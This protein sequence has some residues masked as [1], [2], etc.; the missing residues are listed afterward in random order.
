MKNHAQKFTHFSCCFGLLLVYSAF[1][2]NRLKIESSGSTQITQPAPKEVFAL[3][4]DSLSVL[5]RFIPSGWMGD[6][7]DPERRWVDFDEASKT[8]PHSGSTCVKC[9]YRPGG[10][11]GF[12]A[13]AW[14]NLPDNWCYSPGRDYSAKGFTQIT[15]WARGEAGGELIRFSAGGE[16]CKNGG[17]Y[18]NSFQ[19][20][21]LSVT[22]EQ[23]WKKYTIDLEGYSLKSVLHGFVWSAPMPKDTIVFYLDDIYFR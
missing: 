7:E 23:E 20:L 11:R 8:K 6:G 10:G 2:H 22:L 5:E 18:F 9:T 17:T 14:Q 16:K 1:T 21:P 4:V 19:T 3:A 13:I 12:A 15:F